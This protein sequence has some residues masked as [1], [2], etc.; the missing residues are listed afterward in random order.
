MPEYTIINHSSTESD[1]L[2]EY[3]VVKY[4]IQLTRNEIR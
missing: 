2:P 3:W 1:D 4:T